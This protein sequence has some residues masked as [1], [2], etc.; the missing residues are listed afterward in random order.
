MDGDVIGVAD[1]AVDAVSLGLILSVSEISTSKRAPIG[2]MVVVAIF[3]VAYAVLSYYGS[4]ESGSK[5]LGAALSIGPLLA[6]AAVLNWRWFGWKAGLIAILLS[7]GMLYFW[8]PVLKNHYEWADLVQQCGVY[9]LVAISFARSLF[10]GRVPL[11]SQLTEKLHG[12]LSVKELTYTR[13]ATIVWAFFYSSLTGIILVLFFLASM[14]FWSM[15]V[16]FVS[17]GLI[18]LMFLIDHGIRRVVLGRTGNIFAAIR[19]SLTGS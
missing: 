9:A 18:A 10:G 17:F 11:C 16:N 4:T 13:Y 5:G 1:V 3:I 19:Q 7:A 6:I 8:W 2:R 15:F 14:K 12:P